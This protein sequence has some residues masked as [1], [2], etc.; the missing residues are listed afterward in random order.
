M[1]QR[2]HTGYCQNQARFAAGAKFKGCYNAFVVP[3]Q[4]RCDSAKMLKWDLSDGKAQIPQVN[5]KH[6]TKQSALYT[7]PC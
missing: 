7:T 3:R 1:Q 5:V 4:Q 2:Q 6:D